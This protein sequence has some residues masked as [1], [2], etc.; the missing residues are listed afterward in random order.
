MTY[1][2]F[3]NSFLYYSSED[4]VRTKL[5]HY[6]HIDQDSEV[7]EMLEWL[8]IFG[9]T[10]IDLRDATPAQIL[11][12]IL[13]RKWG[14]EPDDKDMLVMWHKFIYR[15]P[16]QSHE[17]LLTSSLVVI[18]DDQVNTAMAKTVGLPL[19]I[20]TKMVLTGQIRLTGT[21]IPTLPAI[22]EPVL[23]ELEKYGISFTEKSVAWNGNIS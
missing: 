23:G 2:Q 4:P 19:G 9:D 18:G 5:Y 8:G 10:K 20:A 12:L 7:R 15:E 1:K 14:L 17:T 11:E 21:Y 13:C 16:G 6:M 22:Y 3:I